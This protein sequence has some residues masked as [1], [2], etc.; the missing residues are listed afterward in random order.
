M[1]RTKIL[2]AQNPTAVDITAKALPD[3]DLVIVTDLLNTQ[4]QIREKGIDIFVIGIHFDDSRA[5]DLIS[6]IRKDDKYRKTPILILRLLPT[7]IGDTLKWL[8]TL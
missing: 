7:E 6:V 3:Y 5:V 4:Y 8:L 2:I 1:K